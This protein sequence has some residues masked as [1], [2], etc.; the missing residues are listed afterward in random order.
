M[1]EAPQC[2]EGGEAAVQ[3]PSVREHLFSANGTIFI[4]SPGAAPQGL[5]KKN[6]VALT[7]LFTCIC[8]LAIIPQ[9]RNP[10]DSRLQQLLLGENFSSPRRAGMNQRRGR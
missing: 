5:R 9:C 2:P 7:A 1:W 6:S 10:S 4:A 3:L 8:F